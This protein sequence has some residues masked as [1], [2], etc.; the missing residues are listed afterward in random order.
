MTTFTVT[1]TDPAFMLQLR[2]M[3]DQ[4]ISL[5]RSSGS[6]EIA[7][8]LESQPIASRDLFFASEFWAEE[9][10]MEGFDFPVS[11]ASILYKIFQRMEKSGTLTSSSVKLSPSLVDAFWPKSE[12][13]SWGN[14]IYLPRRIADMLVDLISE[15]RTRKPKPERTAQ[16]AL[17]ERLDGKIEVSTPAGKIDVLTETH[18][19]EVKDY[20][21]WKSAIG[22]VQAYSESYPKRQKAIYLIGKT[23]NN[24]KQILK[25]CKRLNIEV[26]GEDF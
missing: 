1:S 20:K 21:G 14:D 11:R 18:V 10:L 19:I 22:Q 25:T 12:Y 15:P 3:S 8:Q 24:L 16:L 23:P 5:L 6:A 2:A 26:M 17:A 7:S 9:S 13:Y 4:R